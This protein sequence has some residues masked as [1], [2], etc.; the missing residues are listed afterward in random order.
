ML[1]DCSV[2]RLVCVVRKSYFASAK[3]VRLKPDTDRISCQSSRTSSHSSK[4]VR[5]FKVS[6]VFSHRDVSATD[7]VTTVHHAA[8]RPQQVDSLTRSSLSSNEPGLIKLCR[9]STHFL[10]PWVQSR[11]VDTGANPPPTSSAVS[12]PPRGWTYRRPSNQPMLFRL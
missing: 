5:C 6:Y 8:G 12:P 1:L 7:C 11:V 4:R 3:R 2:L 10:Q 9:E